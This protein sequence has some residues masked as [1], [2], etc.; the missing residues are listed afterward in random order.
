MTETHA[1]ANY[2]RAIILDL[3]GVIIDSEPLHMES[4]KR[5]FSE[6]RVTVDSEDWPRL[7]GLTPRAVFE[8]LRSKYNLREEIDV[9][10]EKKDRFLAEA[11]EKGLSLFP[12]F[13]PFVQRFQRGFVFA[14]T[15]ST[16]QALTEWVL[17][18]LR[19]EDIFQVVV[20]ADDVLNGK[21]HPE[22]YVKTIEALRLKPSECIVIEDSVN[23]VRAAKGAGAK[24]IAVATSFEREE[25]EEA[26]VVVG[27]LSEITM[28]TLARI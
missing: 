14:L 7:K 18:R 21:P 10:L 28:E 26:D 6:C 16:S 1:D 23:G 17:T 24:C 22:P 25:L 19:L 20:T 27:Q 11:Y 15:T 8:F 2:V 9:F 5:L 13:L 4:E 12:D 3:D